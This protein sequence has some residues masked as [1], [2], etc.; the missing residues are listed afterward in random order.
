[1]PGI[2]SLLPAATE[3]VCALGLRDRLAGVSHECDF[4][5]DVAGLPILSSARVDT[6]ASSALI[7]SGV[8]ALLTEGLSIYRI[9]VDRL[10]ALAPELIVTQD[11]C[12]VCAVPR[13]AL[14]EAVR[15]AGLAATRILS[16]R[17]ETLYE[18]PTDFRRVA[19]AAGVAERG[20]ALAAS[21][22]ERLAKV[23]ARTRAHTPKRVAL[24]EWLEPPMIAGGWMPELARIANL[25][26]LIVADATHF[27]EVSWQD[28]AAADPEVVI[29]IPCGFTEARTR[30]ELLQ[31]SLQTAMAQVRAVHEGRV[32]V[33]DGNAYF[34]RPGPRIADSAELLADLFA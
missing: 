23:K 33:L 30:A 2:V 19:E 25:E 12:D 18:I 9:D 29:L 34:N 15:A 14:E 28:I 6:R 5:E 20:D 31:P 8:R 16:L 17:A 1:L 32:H 13:T 21:F 3:I 26:P 4:P 10:L 11:Q 24:V 22:L 7:D 27:R